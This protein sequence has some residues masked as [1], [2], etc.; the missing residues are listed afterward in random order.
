MSGEE[1]ERPL[2]VVKTASEVLGAIIEAAGDNPDTQAAGRQLG[3]AALTI[4]RT[5]NVILLPLAAVNFAV[6]KARHYFQDGSFE[7]DLR[8]KTKDI[9]PELVIEPKA[10][11]AGP[12]LQAL[13][14]AHEE[15]PLKEL[16]LSLIATSMDGRSA[17]GAHPAFVEIIKQLTAEEASALRPILSRSG[18]FPVIRI[19]K[20][21]R[22]E[23][24]FEILESHIMAIVDWETHE[25]AEYSTREAMMENWARLGLIELGYDASLASKGSYDW[26]EDR[27]EV[28]RWRAK[29]QGDETCEIAVTRGI[30][31][32]TAIGRLFAIATGIVTKDSD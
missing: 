14:F 9:P 26:I 30:V 18:F 12:A 6:D 13:A 4:A 15:A 5:V 22:S 28:K 19:E 10:S 8:E 20:R 24:A 21:F 29:L 1:E 25:P 27:P 11:L 3:K 31:A 2:E 32:R 23:R 16:F 7:R 17:A